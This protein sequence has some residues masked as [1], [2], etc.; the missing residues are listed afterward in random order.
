MLC[1]MKTS[2]GRLFLLIALMAVTTA[3]AHAP[4]AEPATAS[5]RNLIARVD[6]RIEERNVGDAQASRVEGFPY[7]RIDRFLASFRGELSAP[8]VFN[9]WVSRLRTLDREARQVELQNLGAA[10]IF[11]TV[12]ACAQKLLEADREHG[13]FQAA[14][15]NAT[16]APRH[17]DDAARAVGLYP[18]TQIGVALGFE[19]WKD[20]NLPTFNASTSASTNGVIHYGLSRRPLL[21][22]DEVAALIALSSQNAL[23]IAD[24]EGS[25]LIDFARQFSPVFSVQ[26]ETLDDQ[27][28]R[29]Y[30]PSRTAATPQVDRTD[31]T[32]YVRLAHTRFKGEV[33]PQIV[34]T[35]WFPARTREGAFDL[36][37]GNLDGLT[38]RVT[39]G[40]DGKPLLYDTF[41]AC[42]CYHLFFPVAPVTRV[43]V[44]QDHDLREA[45]LVPHEGPVLTI[46]ERVVVHLKAGS[47]YISALS[48]SSDPSV[49][50]I[51]RVENEMVG[52]AFGLRS[53]PLAPDGR[54][55]L[56]DPHGIV[57]G[58][59]RAERFLLWPMGIANAGAMRQW[60]THATAF[61]G[62]RH[63]D[64]AFLLEGAFER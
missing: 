51:L 52:P 59:E 49:D 61:V 35:I 21:S 18:V 10:N 31:P 44:E 13:T 64:D 45:V 2:F 33:L 12:E 50:V 42:G 1:A 25:L 20:Q 40:R 23:G 11:S 27:I 4:D 39:L 55:S 32:I 37:S 58:T 41:H 57:P 43:E 6:A 34:Y 26:Q 63:A 3:C 46:D 5:C 19:R 9:E 28:G 62:E 56:F 30:W 48:V 16:R 7:F 38:W 8:D 14:L 29:P 53:L 36:L 60:G 15:I 54:R 24:L 17:Y 47:H 22:P